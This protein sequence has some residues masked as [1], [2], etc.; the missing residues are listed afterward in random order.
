M[1]IIFK[2]IYTCAVYGIAVSKSG[3]DSSKNCTCIGS[4]GIMTTS[5]IIPICCLT[6]Q[7]AKA[8]T[9][10]DTIADIFAGGNAI[11]CA[12]VN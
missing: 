9:V 2:L 8:S 5:K 11:N 1:A 4:L 10:F 6:A 3:S 12:N 7:G